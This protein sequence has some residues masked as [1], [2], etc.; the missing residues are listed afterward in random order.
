MK[1]LLSIIMVCCM[2]LSLCACGAKTEAPAAAPAAPA[3]APAE[4]PV[5]EAPEA[6]AV[7]W[8][9]FLSMATGSNGGTAFV[10]GSVLCQLVTDNYDTTATAQV[11]TGAGQSIEL[12]RSG[13][14]ELGLADQSACIEALTGKGTFE[15]KA[16]EDLRVICCI[17]NSYWEQLV[18]NASG[19]EDIADLKG[20]KC[21]V[22]GPNSGTLS[23]T[24]KV[25]AA[26]GMDVDKDISPEYIGI[27][28]GI[29]LLQNRQA[30][31]I[32]AIT[33]VPFSSF[34]EL[35]TTDYAHIIGMSDEAIEKMIA[36]DPAFSKGVIPAGTYTNQTEDVNTVLVPYLLV[37]DKS[38]DEEIVYEIVKTIYG[39]IDYL[40][41]QNS[42]F[43]ELDL[44]TA[45]DSITIELHPG[46]ER[47]FNENA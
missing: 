35:T 46:A 32:T 18:T 45:T 20:E 10:A 1:K 44:A 12:V 6:P 9:Q 25:Y 19:I 17:Y 21:V 26:Y 13:D 5:E 29:E 24:S 7:E 15:G 43:K 37:C 27:A 33:P 11:S 41:E 14:C 34:V 31:S 22:G 39:N 8:P 2:I 38:M 42:N 47:F 28:A 30:V 40:T 16:Y 3:E 23:S 4:A 36:D